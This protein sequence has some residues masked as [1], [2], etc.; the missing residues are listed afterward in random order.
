MSLEL[1][2]ARVKIT[3]VTD[4][5]LEAESRASGKDRSEIVR[6]VLN[7]WAE[8]KVHESVLLNK[9]LDAK[10]LSGIVGE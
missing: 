8:K 7:A 6:E 2:D 1:V 3:Q 4:C 9:L 5:V 10:G